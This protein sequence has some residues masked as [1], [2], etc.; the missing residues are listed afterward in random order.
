MVQAEI[1]MFGRSLPHYDTSYSTVSRLF[2]SY[3][4]GG[5][6]TIVF[7]TLRESKALAYSTGSY[8]QG[9]PDTTEP[10]IM[11]GFIGTQ[12]DKLVEAID[13]LRDLLHTLPEIPSTLDIA[14]ASVKQSIASERIVRDN[15]FWNYISARRFGRK[16]DDRRNVYASIDACTMQDLQDFYAKAVKDRCK[17]IAI[18]ADVEKIDMKALEKY[19][20]VRVVKKSALFPYS[21]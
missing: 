1:Y 9:P 7:Q 4:D 11:T 10:Y 15:I 12:A 8:L 19:G 13:G 17:V 14:R 16:N 2:G 20:N 5:M 21:E 3:F 18:L 6:G